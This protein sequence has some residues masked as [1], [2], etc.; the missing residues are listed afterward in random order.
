MPPEE[1]VRIILVE[2]N[3]GDVQLL[4]RTLKNRRIPYEITC[5]EDGDQAIRAMAGWDDLRPDLILLDL[6]LPGREGFDVLSHARQQP[7]LV[8][9]PIGILTSSEAAKDRHRV[10]LIGAERYIHKPPFLEE[11]IKDVGGAIVDLLGMRK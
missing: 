3:P 1:P 7:P 5:Y 6:N 9:I 4:E 8:G 10:A 11:F 2:D